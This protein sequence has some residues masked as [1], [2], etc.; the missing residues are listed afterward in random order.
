LSFDKHVILSIEPPEQTR[1]P[2]SIS[3]EFYDHTGNLLFM[4]LKNEWIGNIDN[5]D[6]ETV[7]RT[8]TIRIGPRR[9]ALRITALPP[10]GIIIERAD[11]FYR[12]TQF[13]VNEYQA[14]LLTSNEGGVTLRGRRIVGHE[15]MTIFLSAYSTGRW[16]IGGGGAFSI[17][18]PPKDPPTFIKNRAPLG[19]NS[20]CLCGS[21]RKFKKCCEGKQNGKPPP[22]KGPM[23]TFE[24]I[25]LR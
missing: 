3:G 19:R 5:W 6:I 25:P 13:T 20:K 10:D 21:G 2:Y 4:I 14:R 12:H 15:S 9:I 11:M 18:G 7:G 24:G 17:E 22:G 1:E 16:T 23:L 8:V